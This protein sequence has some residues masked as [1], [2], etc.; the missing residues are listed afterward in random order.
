MNIFRNLDVSQQRQQLVKW[1]PSR[2]VNSLD[3]PAVSPTIDFK[4]VPSPWNPKSG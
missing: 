3:D 2:V 1:N 4:L